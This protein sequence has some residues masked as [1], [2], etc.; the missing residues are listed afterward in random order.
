[1][2]DTP[3]RHF[4]LGIIWAAWF[5]HAGHGE[6]TYA[7]ELLDNMGPVQSLRRLAHAEGYEFKRGFWREVE[8]RRELRSQ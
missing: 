5:L 3:E 2:G 4:L 8:R 6:D 7:Q 1:M